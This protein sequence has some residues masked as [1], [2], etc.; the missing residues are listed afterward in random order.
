VLGLGP[1]R[2]K[3]PILSH[4]KQLVVSIPVI[5]GYLVFEDG[6]AGATLVT[7]VGA[8]GLSFTSLATLTTGRSFFRN[9]TPGA[10]REVL[11]AVLSGG[12]REFLGF[13]G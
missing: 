13:A 1:S 7:G 6:C 11:S 4:S 12:D 10:V 9:V 3:C 5:G 2:A 8:L